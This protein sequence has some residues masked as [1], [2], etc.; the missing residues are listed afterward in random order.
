MLK[1]SLKETL[2]QTRE[3]W[4]WMRDHPEAI[5]K[6]SYFESKDAPKYT[7]EFFRCFLC[8]YALSKMPLT[9][10]SKYRLDFSWLK[11]VNPKE[12]HCNLHCPLAKVLAKSGDVITSC[13]CE[14]SPTSPY[15]AWQDLR[16]EDDHSAVINAA[17]RMVT[18]MDE[19]LKEN[20]Q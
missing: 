17:Q 18:I 1:L 12:S 3:Q 20:I 8:D 4:A 7:P 15:A 11:G 5:R 19:L 14:D 16:Y 2:L 9:Y 6:R 13:P 10:M